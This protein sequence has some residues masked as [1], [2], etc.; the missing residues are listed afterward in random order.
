VGYAIYDKQFA[1]FGV[2]PFFRGGAVYTML[3]LQVGAEKRGGCGGS[4]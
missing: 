4:K 2:I 1:T 3:F